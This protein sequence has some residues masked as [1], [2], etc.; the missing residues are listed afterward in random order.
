MRTYLLGCLLVL[1]SASAAVAQVSKEDATV[2]QASVVLDEIMAAQLKAIPHWLLKD[3]EAIAVIPNVVKGSFVVG[4]RHGKGVVLIRDEAGGWQA[5][6]FVSLTGGSVG[7]QIGVQS[8]DVI[9][10]FKTRKSVEGLLKGKFTIGAD[11]AAAAGPVGR[12]AAAATDERLKA[13]IYSYSRA[14]GL[15][16]GVSLD[17]SV[18]EID[19]TAAANYYRPDP[20]LGPEVAEAIPIPESAAQLMQRVAH[21]SAGADIAPGDAPPPAAPEDL[22]ASAQALRGQLAASSMQLQ[23]IIDPS[24]QRYLAL[25]PE[26]YAGDNHASPEAVDAVLKNYA[27]VAAQRQYGALTSRPEFRATHELL[28]QYA[29]ALRTVGAPTLELPPPPR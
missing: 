9:L 25:P 13:E 5:P 24:W 12:Q 8:T 28:L 1:L 20:R 27:S 29:A 14:R 18:L 3:S 22:A 26:I 19:H 4:V 7:F 11:A 21:Y 16:A 2:Q 10:V 23:K 15:F 17:G 6:S